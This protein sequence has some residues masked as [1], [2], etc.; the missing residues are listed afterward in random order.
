MQRYTWMKRVYG[1]VLG[2][3]YCLLARRNLL[4][5]NGGLNAALRPRQKIVMPQGHLL[6]SALT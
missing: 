6:E 2:M 3:R 4:L 1:L 5:G